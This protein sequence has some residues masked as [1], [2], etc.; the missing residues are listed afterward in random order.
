MA[1]I[2]GTRGAC[3]CTKPRVTKLRHT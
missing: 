2:F 3:I 1:D